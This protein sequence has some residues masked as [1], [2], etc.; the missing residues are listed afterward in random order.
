M[1]D[2]GEEGTDL[3]IVEEYMAGGDVDALLRGG[4]VPVERTLEIDTDVC[5]ALSFMHGQGLVHRDLKPSNVFL[6]EDG[7]AKVGDF[8]LTT[9]VDLAR[10]TQQGMMVGTVAYMPPEQALG[11][12]VTPQ[13]DLYSLRAM[14]YEMVTGAPPFQADEPTAI[15]SQHINTPP[16]APSWHTEACPPALEEL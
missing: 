9:A 6:T 14:L 3:F 5:R 4:D 8:G 16:V 10:I 11:G 15:I 13:S 7:T 2:V 1:F 12:D